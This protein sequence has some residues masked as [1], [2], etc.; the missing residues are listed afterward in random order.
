MRREETWREGSLLHSCR[1]LELDNKIGGEREEGLGWGEGV[2]EGG[3]RGQDSSRS[4]LWFSMLGLVVLVFVVW[5]KGRRRSVVETYPFLF[6]N[7]CG[8]HKRKK[9]KK[10]KRKRGRIN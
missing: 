3:D 6:L 7:E 10:R 2:S 8:L 1:L 4:S 5:K 9:K